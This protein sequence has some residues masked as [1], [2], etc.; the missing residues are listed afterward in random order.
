MN[1][2][3]GFLISTNKFKDFAIG[4]NAKISRNPVI[5]V[6]QKPSKLK[7]RLTIE[8]IKRN[9]SNIIREK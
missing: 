1:R 4:K 5:T 8:K 7:K 2:I 3:N 6:I 9:A